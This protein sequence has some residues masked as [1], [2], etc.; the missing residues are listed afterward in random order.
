MR[1]AQHVVAFSDVA[2]SE[3]GII[4]LP[5][6]QNKTGFAEA[7]TRQ[8]HGMKW[9]Y[10]QRSDL[11]SKKWFFF[12]DDDTWVKTGFAFGV[13]SL[14]NSIKPTDSTL[15]WSLPGECAKSAT[16][17]LVLPRNTSSVL[18][19]YLLEAQQSSVQR[20]CWDVVFYSSFS[21]D[22][23]CHFHQCMPSF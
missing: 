8:L 9:I 5:E 21:Q 20:W 4:T 18:L 7:Q 22:C 12:V 23:C 17:H 16:V 14:H 15:L 10:H 3:L 6:I 13:T 11:T 19:S 2:D 1:W